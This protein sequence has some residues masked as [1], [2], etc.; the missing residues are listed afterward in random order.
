MGSGEQSCPG[1]ARPG[2]AWP[3]EPA[4]GGGRAAAAL[5]GAQPGTCEEKL[6]GLLA[7]LHFTNHVYLNSSAVRRALTGKALENWTHQLF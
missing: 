7:P 2:P 5:P 4:G 1:R 6:P 3:L